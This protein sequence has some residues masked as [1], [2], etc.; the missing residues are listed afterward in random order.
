MRT[1]ITL[2]ED[3]AAQLHQIMRERDLTFKDAVN[4]T[5]RAGLGAQSE[6]RAYRL[7]TYRMGV[8]PGIDLDHALRLDAALEDE[9]TVRQLRLRK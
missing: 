2:D 7:P 6:A 4:A 1:T 3:V 8:R 9:E 5:L